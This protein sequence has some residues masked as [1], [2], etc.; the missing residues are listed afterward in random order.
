MTSTM[1]HAFVIRCRS[2]K[3]IQGVAGFDVTDPDRIYR[4]V[5]FVDED[6]WF[7][8]GTL[9]LEVVATADFNEFLSDHAAGCEF[10]GG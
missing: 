2:C 6:G 1:T 3:A 9:V 5:K 10:G 7:S 8:D 4:A